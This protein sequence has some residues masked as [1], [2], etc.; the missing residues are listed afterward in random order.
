MF[1]LGIGGFRNSGIKDNLLILDPQF[2]NCLITTPS[3]GILD[4][5]FGILDLN[6]AI[7]GPDQTLLEY[8]L[9]L[10]LQN[11]NS[12]NG[13]LQIAPGRAEISNPK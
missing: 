7:P 3:T 8:A 6:S 13:T 10:L 4:F 11:I 5:G 12:S 2:L 9:N 1:N